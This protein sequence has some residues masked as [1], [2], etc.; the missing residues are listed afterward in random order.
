MVSPVSALERRTDQH[1]EPDAQDGM[2]PA[3]G[4][5]ESFILCSE[6]TPDF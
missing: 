6:A 4:I 5:R 3:Q 2:P 1:R